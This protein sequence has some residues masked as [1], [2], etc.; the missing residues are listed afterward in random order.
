MDEPLWA[1]Q[2]ALIA[3]LGRWR[4]GVPPAAPSAGNGERAP[5]RAAA[6]VP[7]APPWLPEVEMQRLAEQPGELRG[8]LL[9][10]ARRRLASFPYASIHPGWL[11]PALPAEPLVRQWC[12]ALLPP[13]VRERLLP[14]LP[15]PRGT[16]AVRLDPTGPPRWFAAWWRSVLA[17]RLDYPYAPPWSLRADQ[18]LTFL[19]RL[20]DAEAPLLLRRYGLRLV[21]AGV[22]RLPHAEVVQWVYRFPPEQRDALVGLVRE[23]RF[24][25]AE[26]WAGRLAALAEGS[27]P[28]EVPLHL[29]LLDVAV[30]ARARGGGGDARRLAYRL[31]PDLGRELLATLD[32]AAD[33]ELAALAAP[34]A[35]WDALVREDLDAL[36]AAGIVSRPDLAEEAA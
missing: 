14:L 13:P 15:R 7:P 16:G 10:L 18:P 32:A 1:W 23:R 5:A 30:Q 12:V 4:Q 27:A 28:V 3:A 29:A 25:E 24:P 8:A 36:I 34:A 6:L 22:S 31:A 9:E 26:G 2:E 33:P 19:W 17:A 20:S 11:V 35:A 21:A